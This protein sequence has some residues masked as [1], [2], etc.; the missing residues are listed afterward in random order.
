MSTEYKGVGLETDQGVSGFYWAWLSTL[1]VSLTA[2]RALA[3]CLVWIATENGALAAAMILLANSLPRIVFSLFAGVIIDRRGSFKTMLTADAGMLI[4]CIV[5]AVLTWQNSSL[6]LWLLLAGLMGLAEGFYIPASGSVPKI[7]VP[8]NRL[9]R[10]M[11]GQQ[12]VNQGA[13]VLSPVLGGL[14]A[15]GIGVPAGAA[16]AAAGYFVMAMLLVGSKAWTRDVP[17][18]QRASSPFF[19]SLKEGWQ[20]MMGIPLLRTTL[21]LTALFML[22]M[23][24]ITSFFL[25]LLSRSMGWDGKLAGSVSAAY[26][27][28]M[29]AVA[30]LVIWRGSLPRPGI[31][32]SAGIVLLGASAMLL[33]TT[34]SFVAV[35][36]IAASGGVGASL[37]STHLGPLFV[38]AA[39]RQFIGRMQSLMTLAQSIP[40][41]VAPLILGPL[42]QSI[43]PATLL[44]IWG[45]LLGAL[46]LGVWLTPSLRVARKLA[47][48]L[49]SENG[50]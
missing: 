8:Q 18:A 17:A 28:G 39:P 43:H 32:I 16:V 19:K 1:A 27:C 5:F 48:I 38:G 46:G 35:A 12:L 10:A 34:T 13:A 11:A 26:A 14:L 20:T 15:T 40:L 29:V 44:M 22:L 42:G 30:A 33:T 41:L 23:P 7:L 37:F 24:P 4:I 47:P 31:A 9:P 45:C 49:T 6:W 2:S 36:V 21:V 3:F 25:P 50:K